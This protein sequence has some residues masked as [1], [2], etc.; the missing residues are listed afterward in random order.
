MINQLNRPDAPPKLRVWFG[1]WSRCESFS[2]RLDYWSFGSRREQTLSPKLF[3]DTIETE[4]G[5]AWFLDS[6]ME[7]DLRDLK[8]HDVS[9]VA[10]FALEIVG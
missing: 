10:R 3:T 1:V 8:E 2:V 5:I 6:L 7:K 4:S 9:T